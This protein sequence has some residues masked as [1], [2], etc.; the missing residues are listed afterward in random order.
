MTVYFHASMMYMSHMIYTQTMIAE[1]KQ[2]R[3][4]E[5]GKKRGR[6]SD[7]HKGLADIDSKKIT[8][9]YILI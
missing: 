8:Y 2:P 1:L 4:M 9:N 5:S 7:G 6:E 3:K